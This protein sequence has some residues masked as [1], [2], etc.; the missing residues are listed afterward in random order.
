MLFLPTINEFTV[1]YQSVVRWSEE[2]SMVRAIH[3]PNPC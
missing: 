2:R 3:I 1:P